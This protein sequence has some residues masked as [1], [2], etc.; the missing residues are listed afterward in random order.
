MLF[1]EVQILAY[2]EEHLPKPICLSCYQYDKSRLICGGLYCHARWL[3]L[4]HH[5]LLYEWYRAMVGGDILIKH[6]GTD[7]L[8]ACYTKGC[9][10][11]PRHTRKRCNNQEEAKKRVMGD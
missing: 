6:H 8:G 2:N 4:A 5:L 11:L 7:A 9:Y 3:E 1:H 10:A